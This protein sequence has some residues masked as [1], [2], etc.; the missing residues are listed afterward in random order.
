MK[1]K[2][3][4]LNWVLIVLVLLITDCTPRPETVTPKA[5]AQAVAVDSTPVPV[6]TSTPDAR[7]QARQVMQERMSQCTTVQPGYACLVQ[8]PV[9][10]ESQP[11]QHLKTFKAPGDLILL[12]GLQRMKL[13]SSGSPDGVVWLRIPGDTPGEVFSVMAFGDVELTN[14]VPFGSTEFSGMQAFS[15]STGEAVDYDQALTRGLMV[16]APHDGT[17]NTLI[18]NGVEMVF[19]STAFLT[20]MGGFVSVNT[21]FGAVG[22]NLPGIVQIVEEGKYYNV[23]REYT[24]GSS[25]NIEPIRPLSEEEYDALQ[26]RFGHDYRNDITPEKVPEERYRAIMELANAILWGERQAASDAN[27]IKDPPPPL[28]DAQWTAL[29]NYYGRSLRELLALENVGAERYRKL[30]EEANRILNGEN[31]GEGDAVKRRIEEKKRMK[32][33]KGGWWKMT[34]GPSTVSGNCKAEAVGDGMGGG[35]ENDYY[36]KEVPICR[37]NNGRTI[38]MYENGDTFQ[39]TGPNHYVS[40]YMEE[41]ENYGTGTYVTSGRYQS[42]QVLSPT[43]MRID[44]VRSEKDG[45]TTTHSVFLDFLRDDPAIRCGKIIEITPEPKPTPLETTVPTP[46]PVPPQPP[47]KVPYTIRLGV[48]KKDCVPQAKEALPDFLKTGGADVRLNLTQPGALM[49]ETLSGSYLLALGPEF[50]FMSM[51]DNSHGSMLGIY[52]LEQP[53]NENY[54]LSL[55]LMQVSAEQYGGTWQVYSQ[56]GE[57]YC[58]GSVDLLAQKK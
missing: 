34:Y 56:D 8:G 2:R 13:G 16:D 12:A 38:L 37:G 43:R 7:A 1:D 23:P 33:W 17:L 48:V 47:V 6:Q 39:Q 41:I 15:F 40:G 20:S 5:A 27:W 50:N 28:T 55:T 51:R 46:T 36:T 44:F 14:D 19:G 4:L 52:T 11:G 25:A 30:A 29:E 10:V 31:P 21:L 49:L 18:I 32:P 42:L 45:C 53:I 3:F 24:T 35:G 57:Q 54:G 9:V 58:T 22:L 26:R